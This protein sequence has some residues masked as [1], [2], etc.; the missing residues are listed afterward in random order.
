M[1]YNGQI[2]QMDVLFLDDGTLVRASVD[3]D[4]RFAITPGQVEVTDEMYSA[5]G[6]DTIVD[7]LGNVNIT[8]ELEDIIREKYPELMI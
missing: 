6:V 5:V 7:N 3:Y 2:L 1:K 8:D 4:E